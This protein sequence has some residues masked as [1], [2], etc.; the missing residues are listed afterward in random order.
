[1]SG[2]MEMAEH[3]ES[4]GLNTI[5]SKNVCYRHIEEKAIKNYIRRNAALGACDYCNKNTKVISL[6]SLM[7]FVMDT[8]VC[9][10][11]D[12][13]NFLSY[14]GREGGYLGTTYDI[15]E[16]FQDH[17]ELEV[18]DSLFN[19]FYNSLDINKIWASELDYRDSPAESLKYSWDYFKD[20]VK[21]RS[22]YYFGIVKDL[23]STDY[24]LMPEMILKEIGRH[25]K[26]Y[27]LIRKIAPNTNIYRCRQ[28][29]RDDISVKTPEGM[30]SPPIEYALFSN[31]MSPAGISMFYGAF[32]KDTT[33][34]EVVDNDDVDKPCYTIVK[35]ITKDEINVIDL[36]ALPPI[37][38]PFDMRRRNNYYP[39]I[40][41]YSFANDLAKPITGNSTHI[42]YV[43]T[44]IITEYFRFPFSESLRDRIDGIIYR[45]SR[46]NNRACVLFYDNS[47]SLG[48]LEYDSQSS[49]SY[50][51]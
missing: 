47:E 36:T 22:R 42:D 1:M 7:F 20:I 9:F 49:M 28:H 6:E 32:E 51:I 5:P 15:H 38:S 24:R 11:T 3:L 46:D 16:I 34:A 30:T 37:P 17:F 14:N 31:R 44:Q 29:G 2:V 18:D 41:L 26:K 21:H 23:N 19:D 25:I 27:K 4:L 39:L 12:A 8:V 33:I 45:S 48:I 50:E 40:F 10:Y 13:V 43:P 35:F